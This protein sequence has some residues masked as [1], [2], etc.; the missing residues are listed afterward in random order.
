[1]RRVGPPGAEPAGRGG[2]P[3]QSVD[4]CRSIRCLF[5]RAPFPLHVTIV[6]MLMV[7]PDALD[8]EQIVQKRSPM[9]AAR[10]LEGS[11]ARRDIE[12]PSRDL[13]RAGVRRTVHHSTD[14]FALLPKALRRGI[15]RFSQLREPVRY[16][17]DQSLQVLR[18]ATQPVQR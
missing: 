12:Q 5:P 2:A 14:A 17:R 13:R 18:T 8:A 4:R 10:D 11:P 1:M 7:T 6:H 16:R 9:L 15:W 3:P